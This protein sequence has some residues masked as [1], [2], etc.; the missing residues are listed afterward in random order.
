MTKP[1]ADALVI[2][3]GPAGASIA[4]R[5]ARQGWRVV[6]VEQNGYP[7]QK[8]CGECL[9]PAS[10][11]L[12]D[13]LGLGSKIRALA[14]PSIRQVAW[15]VGAHTTVGR[16]PA[17]RTGLYAHGCAIGRDVLDLLILEHARSQGVEVLQPAKVRRVHG[18]PGHFEC[19]C[20]WR[21]DQAAAKHERPAESRLTASLVIDAHGSWERG[22]EYDPV[23]H[24]NAATLR[25]RAADLLAF[26]ATFQDSTLEPGVLPVLCLP[27]G[28]GGMVVSDRGRTT[29]ACCIR[30]DTLSLWRAR[31]GEGS[32]GDAVDE[33]LR[34]SCAGVANVLGNAQRREPWLAVG[35]LRTGFHPRAPRG[36]LRIGNAAAE[37]H[38]LIGEGICMA[39]QSARLLA[40]LCAR[41]PAQLDVPFILHLQRA[42]RLISRRDFSARMRL[43]QLFAQVAMRPSLAAVATVLLKRCPSALTAAAALAGKARA[44]VLQRA[45]CKVAA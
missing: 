21:S 11:E 2:G 22:P 20:E 34:S 19:I 40:S 7:R 33:Y 14:G 45:P 25:P 39:L 42:Q 23:G 26:K 4:I 24:A 8:V 43:A 44:G 17:R 9:G 13:E 16:M 32:A 10:L 30:R 12:L 18:G 3:A 5:L 15:M 37:A 28:Y 27:G 31:V 38:P 1:D 36:V 29:V 35:A 6:L 41:R